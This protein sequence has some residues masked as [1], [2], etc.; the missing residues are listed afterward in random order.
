[1]HLKDKGLFIELSKK[2]G[3]ERVIYR[4]DPVII[5][6]NVSIELHKEEFKKR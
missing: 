1:M 6:D 4:Y 5:T 3:K 2:I